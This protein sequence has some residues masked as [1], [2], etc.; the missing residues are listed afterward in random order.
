MSR[1]SNEEEEKRKKRGRVGVR[2]SATPPQHIQYANPQS[3]LSWQQRQYL[4]QQQA[5]L[6]QQQRF[7]YK[8]QNQVEQQRK[9]ES[10]A[11]VTFGSAMVKLVVAWKTGFGF[12]QDQDDA[13]LS[14]HVPKLVER[15]G[16]EC[17]SV[18]GRDI[19]VVA[20]E[21]FFGGDGLDG[22]AELLG[23]LAAG[24]DE[25]LRRLWRQA[26][27]ADFQPRCAAFDRQLPPWLGAV[28]EAMAT[29]G[30]DK[31]HN[32]LVWAQVFTHASNVADLTNDLSMS[33][34]RIEYLGDLVL[35]ACVEQRAAE[36]KL[37]PD[38]QLSYFG[39]N[40][41]IK[42]IMAELNL[43]H[44]LRISRH[45]TNKVRADLYEAFLGAL[46]IERGYK[47]SALFVDTT[48]LERK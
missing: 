39:Q 42:P 10:A 3:H 11:H 1:N 34:E 7:L 31:W 23:E 15:L 26:G 29:I 8:Q 21:R 37:P 46:F 41:V 5:M 9:Q 30:L 43:A 44:H 16:R 45:L 28:K 32:P 25:R 36:G 20:A 2:P 40:R 18:C 13:E 12:T 22:V 38:K 17:R 4:E 33:Y 24:N 47:C 48:L 6:L 14:V 27:G 35:A 19:G